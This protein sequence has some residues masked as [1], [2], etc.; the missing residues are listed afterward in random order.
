MIVQP[1]PTNPQSSV[2]RALRLGGLVLPLV[3]LMVVAGAGV[4]G[5]RPEVAEPGQ[6]TTGPAAASPVANAATAFAQPAPPTATPT[7][8]EPVAPTQFGDLAVMTTA[9]ALAQGHA[10][11]SG[12]AIAVNGYLRLIGAA[13]PGCPTAAIDPLGPWCERTGVL[14]DWAWANGTAFSSPTAP[15]LHV[16][17][18]AGVRVPGVLTVDADGLAGGGAHVMVIG[19]I[20]AHREPCA[21]SRHQCDEVLVVDRFA[22]VDGNRVGITPLVA[23]RLSTGTKRANPFALAL[24]EAELPLM[25][26]LTWPNGVAAIDPDVAAA[27]E[28]GPPS[29]PVWYMR[30]LDGARGPGMER[31]VLWLLLTEKDLRV[32][33]AGRPLG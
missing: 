9:A 1:T 23:D 4:L 31:R 28:A 33:D 6:S 19:R 14:A 24:D 7:T 17:I 30:V 11:V 18:P 5:P 2:R 22:W 32:I 27:A 13:D 25:A 26:V 12:V 10:R 16:S 3:L 20:K 8:P 21:G 29:V 15:Y